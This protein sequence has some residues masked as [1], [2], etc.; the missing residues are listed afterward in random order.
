M[1]SVSHLTLY[2]ASAGSG[3]TFMLTVRYISFLARYPQSYRSILAVTFTNKATAEMKQ[4]I[5]EQLY[6]IAHSLPSSDAYFGAV[7]SL[8]RPDISDQSIRENARQALTLILQDY[9]NF[10]VE[11]I[12]SFFQTVLRG[13]ARELQIGSNLTLELDHKAVISDAVDS[14]LAGVSSDSRERDCIIGYIED[15]IDDGR[16]WNISQDL[17]KFAEELFSEVFMEKKDALEGFQSSDRSIRGYALQMRE[18]KAKTLEDYTVRLKECGEEFAD[19]FM[20]KIDTSV[21]KS[22]V[23]SLADSIASAS[24]LDKETP[25]ALTNALEDTAGMFRVAAVRKD[26]GLVGFAEETAVPVLRKVLEI[27]NGYQYRINSIS[28]VTA[29]LNELSLLLS[30]RR[31]INSQCTENSSFVLADT[32]HLLSSLTIGDTSFVF[33]KTGSFI[34]HLMIDEFQD[35]SG[36]QWKNLQLLISESLSQNEDCLVV[37]DVKQSIYR[38]RNSDWNI[39]N[40]EIE[41]YYRRYS[42]NTISLDTNRRS[43][44]NIIDFNNRLFPAV[45]ESVGEI[46]SSKFGESHT[47]L[48][49]AYSDVCQKWP[50]LDGSDSPSRPGG[51]VKARFL[52]ESRGKMS[53]EE[54]SALMMDMIE[55]ELDRLIA[56][57]TKPGDITLLLREKKNISR[58]ANHFAAKRPEYNMVSGEAFRLDSS[59]SVRIIVNALRWIADGSDLVALASM[60]YEWQMSA[61]GVA[62]T[63]HDIFRNDPLSLLPVG[64]C[65][66]ETLKNIPMYELVEY[67]Y[68]TMQLDRIAGQGAYVLFFMDTVRNFATRNSSDLADLVTAWDERLCSLT[69]PGDST[70]SISLM[71]IHKS[72]GLEFHTVIVPFCEWE[73]F[74]SKGRIWC[75]PLEEPYSGMPLVSVDCKESL[76]NSIFKKEY[77]EETGK[78]MVD[79]LNILYVA[80]TRPVCNLVI[81]GSTPPPASG[82]DNVRTIDKILRNCLGRMDDSTLTADGFLEYETGTMMPSTEEK[83][84]ESSD[85]PFVP[86]GRQED[87]QMKSYGIRASFRQSGESLRF[88][89]A[90]EDSENG[91]TPQEEYINNGKL[92][93]QL[94]S[95]IGTENDIDR[96][97]H[98]MLAQGV[99][100]SRKRAESVSSL[101]HGAMHIPE[102]ARWFDGHWTLFNE[103]SVLF[104]KGGRLFRRRPDRVMADDRETIVVDYKFG[105][106]DEEHLH[107]V[108]EYMELLD[109]MGFKNIKGYVWYPY[110]NKITS[111]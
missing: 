96:A 86:T 11:T 48:Q 92:L 59:V 60:I 32:A 78:Q 34:R 14:M 50:M 94:L 35:T 61:E 104:R 102:I 49:K 3:K 12:D 106:A 2:K 83:K 36:M 37:G 23:I 16:N 28:A 43:C 67:I 19:V 75:E 7:R 110:S 39:L 45:M 101:L 81:L 69:I 51:Y 103:T 79:S 6:G 10:R 97:V 95:M 33:E 58:I 73:L 100:E 17:K 90:D 91:G 63:F 5:L 1:A 38:W 68:K 87:I 56:T 15:K 76:S 31:E 64:M 72:K 8:V 111:C 9:S 13:L 26:A 30:I 41:E 47:A 71:T 107:Q 54:S 21:L 89:A 57:G 74:S 40:S 93:H 22:N 84:I 55:E 46:Y 66:R 99:I 65:R 24:I 52:A 80:L 98:S 77:T 44:A 25:K 29:H 70:D 88:A 27:C 82:T 109:E 85:N 108:Q 18:L 62:M 53:S 42:P 105:K 4:R 20:R